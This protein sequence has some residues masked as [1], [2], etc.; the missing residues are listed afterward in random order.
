MNND[1]AS[2]LARSVFSIIRQRHLIILRQLEHD[3]QISGVQLAKKASASRRTII[4]DIEE[5]RQLFEKTIEITATSQGYELQINDLAGYQKKK[6]LLLQDD[7]NLLFLHYLCQQ[8][9]NLPKV[10][11]EKTGLSSQTFNKQQRHIQQVLKEY[12][13]YL[14]KKAWCIKGPEANLRIFYVAFYFTEEEQPYTFFDQFSEELSIHAAPSM[15]LDKDKVVKWIK[16]F[17]LRAKQGGQLKEQPQLAEFCQ[18]F[19]SK[20]DFRVSLSNKALLFS[21]QELCVLAFLMLDEEGLLSFL[22]CNNWIEKEMPFSL[23]LLMK[24]VF[25]SQPAEDQVLANIALA[26]LLL[27]KLFHV[28]IKA[29]HEQ[30]VLS[31]DE[32]N[33][34]PE[35][36]SKDGYH[37]LIRL[38]KI[39]LSEQKSLQNQLMIVYYL[40]GPKKIQ[41]WI[42]RE[43][44]D[45]LAQQGINVILDNKKEYS[46][47]RVNQIVVT[48][49]QLL[50]MEPHIP[51]YF[52]E[53]SATTESIY[54]L[55]EKIYQDFQDTVA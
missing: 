48:D 33:G 23:D 43:L 13:L 20:T 4:S 5:L 39:Y 22:M 50:Y 15:P 38:G 8:I 19:L 12:G 14:D 47:L 7:P 29:T 32:S 44:N 31:L 52:I 37:Y 54:R 9:D 3:D 36:L 35:V 34:L 28:P 41:Q 24:H 27:D 51:V 49:H 26:V 30:T 17:L 25:P 21:D 18:Q 6:R 45:C 11:T 40:Q 1:G 10:L 42:Q 55:G 53:R 2:L 16:V 46:F